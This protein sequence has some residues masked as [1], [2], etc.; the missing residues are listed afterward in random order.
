MLGERAAVMAHVKTVAVKIAMDVMVPVPSPEMERVKAPATVVA[1][2][3]VGAVDGAVPG[4][5]A[6]I[7]LH[8][9]MQKANLSHWTRP[10]HLA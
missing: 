7:V 3:G 2:A 4:G 1:A 10:P 8:A 9:L 6:P 5:I